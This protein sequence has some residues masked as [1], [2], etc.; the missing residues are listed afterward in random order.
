[1]SSARSQGASVVIRL[2]ILMTLLSQIGA[3]DRASGTAAAN[4]W[5]RY[6]NVHKSGRLSV[7]FLVTFALRGKDNE[8]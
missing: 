2:A 7:F 4:V 5:L 8:R 6:V 3:V 1:M